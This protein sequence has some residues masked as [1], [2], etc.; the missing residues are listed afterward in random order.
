[1]KASGLKVQVPVFDY[2][3]AARSDKI[4]RAMQV[5]EVSRTSAGPSVTVGEAV[6]ADCVMTKDCQTN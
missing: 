5:K 2:E 4:V 3:D 1:L 6:I